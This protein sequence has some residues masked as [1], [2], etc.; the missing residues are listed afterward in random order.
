MWS[1]EKLQ[2]RKREIGSW[3]FA[4]EYLNDPVADETQ[5][6]KSE[7]IRYWKEMPQQYSGVI[8]VD[9]AYS[10]DESSDF[11]V[12][13]HICIDQNSNRYL[14]E[15]IRTHAPTGEFQDAILDM[16]LRNKSHI[17]GV[18]LP[19]GG[20][21][22]EFFN[23]FL[24]KAEQR[25]IYPPIVELKNSFTTADGNKKRNKKARITASLQPLFEQGK[26]YINANHLE[27][28]DEL[29]TIGASRWDD[30]VDT[31]AYAEQIIQPVYFESKPIP[32]SEWEKAGAKP[33]SL[34]YG[35][36]N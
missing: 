22:T 15:Y 33:R 14:V 13:T 18:G 26:Y 20:G 32:K 28:R 29:L 1:H 34:D 16:Y 9:P 12:C 36:E 31:L 3:A 25:R 35:Y 21:D 6:I 5:P 8:V 7:M 10:E 27:A 19:T 30:V 4:A 23:S 11:K 24:K 2:E 17:T